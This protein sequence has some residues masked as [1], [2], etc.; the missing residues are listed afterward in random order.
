MAFNYL[1]LR[2]FEKVALTTYE[3]EPVTSRTNLYI[4]THST[5]VFTH[6]MSFSITDK[7]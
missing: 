6:L 5:T 4:P 1:I 2:N 3:I 7:N